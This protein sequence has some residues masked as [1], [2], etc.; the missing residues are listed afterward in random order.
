MAQCYERNRDERPTVPRIAS[1]RSERYQV[2][3][4]IVIGKWVAVERV[5]H[6]SL[7]F[8]AMQGA[9]FT[10][11]SRIVEVIGATDDARAR[12]PVQ[13]RGRE[14]RTAEGEDEG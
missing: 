2:I 1:V 10:R 7:L 5:L 13:I 4:S 9:V 6:T 12:R 3:T 8:R 11:D 14:H